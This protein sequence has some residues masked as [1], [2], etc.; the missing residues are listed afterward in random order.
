MEQGLVGMD[1]GGALFGF[2]LILYIYLAPAMVAFIRAHPRFWIILAL[3]IV[4]APVQSVLFQSLLGAGIAQMDPVQ[5]ALRIGLLVML[6]PG[7]VA[8]MGW[9]AYAKVHAP[10]AKLLA[11]RDTK[12]F[13]FVAALPLIA[14][15]VQS[16]ML[17]RPRLA[18]T[19]NMILAGEA[20]LLLWLLFF[21]LLFSALFC[22]LSVWLLVIR[23][24]PV[25]RVQG[26]LPRLAAVSGTFVGVGMLRLPVADL[27]LGMQALA[28]FLTG[29]GSAASAVVLWRLGKSFSIMPEARTLVT[30]G[31]YNY[32]RHPLYA[33]EIITV[34]GMILQYQQPWALVMGGAVIA[35]QVI[36]SL[37]EEKVLVQAFPE[38]VA[39]RARTKRFIPGVI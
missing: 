23:D 6:G 26:L 7:W 5:A 27:G 29:F 32:I 13:D 20:G 38:Y 14:W 28:F 39:Y 3:N 9:A 11:W 30:Q 35:L 4:L 1:S 25:L 22:L 16:A 19:G 8:L 12:A 15:F 36:R 2:I 10:D 21:S 24:K 33:A 18:E 37:Y 34:F 17:M 31:P